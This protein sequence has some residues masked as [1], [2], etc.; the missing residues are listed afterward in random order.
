[1]LRYPQER[2]WLSNKED[3]VI[4]GMVQ[5]GK[6]TEISN[7]VRALLGFPVPPN[8]EEDSRNQYIPGPYQPGASCRAP[9]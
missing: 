2:D 8:I 9:F 5:S 6:M 3:R 4:E 7:G 1:M